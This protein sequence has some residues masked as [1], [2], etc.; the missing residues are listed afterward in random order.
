[1]L[2]TFAEVHETALDILNL[3]EPESDDP[4]QN[5]TIFNKMMEDDRMQAVDRIRDDFT[6]LGLGS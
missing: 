6:L 4:D 1:M 5:A 3:D 2:E